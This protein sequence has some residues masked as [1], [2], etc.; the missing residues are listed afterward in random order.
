[1]K[2][3]GQLPGQSLLVDS[4]GRVMKGYPLG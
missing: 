2:V 4:G 1:V 3:N